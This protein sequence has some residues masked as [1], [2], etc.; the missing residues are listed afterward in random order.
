[1]KSQNLCFCIR[2]VNQK[3]K[4]NGVGDEEK[5]SNHHHKSHKKRQSSCSECSAYVSHLVLVK[6][7]ILM[8]PEVIL[9]ALMVVVDD[10]S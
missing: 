4:E 1:M 6:V 2:F 7:A 9:A 8:A 3:S 5:L 10:L